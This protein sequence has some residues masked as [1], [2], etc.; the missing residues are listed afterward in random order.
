VCDD[1]WLIDD[2]KVQQFKED[3]DAYPKWLATRK[4]RQAAGDE[5][6]PVKGGNRKKQ[7]RQEAAA[8]RLL[9]PQLNRLRLLESEIEK[10]TRRKAE[11]ETQLGESELYQEAQKAR[12]TT[13]LA[14]QATLLQELYQK[15]DEWM[16]LSEEV[17]ASSRA[18]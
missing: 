2:G 8:R 17:E 5:V 11:M 13:M 10:L 1:L 4:Q 12:L 14:E 18:D 16:A 9:Q 3:I 7:K 6:A 15:E